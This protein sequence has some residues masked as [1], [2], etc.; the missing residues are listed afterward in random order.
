MDQEATWCYA[1]RFYSNSRAYR[2]YATVDIQY[3]FRRD[4]HKLRG[5]V[6]ATMQDSLSLL[7]V[8]LQAFVLLIICA[9]K[10]DI[11]CAGN[12]VGQFIRAL[13]IQQDPTKPIVLDT[14]DLAPGGVEV[15]VSDQLACTQSTAIHY[16]CTL[17]KCLCQ[18]ADCALLDLPTLCQE[19]ALQVIKV[20]ARIDHRSLKRVTICVAGR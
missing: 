11:I 9:A 3:I 13:F 16:N 7:R 5:E 19:V 6:S 4:A 1:F 15:P 20:D 12:D 18:V 10:D 17:R 8:G 2:A 14:Y